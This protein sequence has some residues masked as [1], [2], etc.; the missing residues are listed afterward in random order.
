MLL[1]KSKK[2]L[3]GIAAAAATAVSAQAAPISYS[4]AISGDLSQDFPAEYIG[5]LDIGINTIQGTFCFAR[6][7][8]TCPDTGR[9]FD[10]DGFRYT[11][12]EGLSLDSVTYAFASASVLYAGAHTNFWL[13]QGINLGDP[14]L[15]G[16][17]LDA[18]TSGTRS[19]FASALPISAPGEYT[20]AQPGSGSSGFDGGLLTVNYMWTLSV[21]AV[22]VP[23]PT[24]LGLFG[25][26]LAALLS[27]RRRNREKHPEPRGLKD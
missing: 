26:G 4:E 3:A 18:M 22:E 12:P 1:L 20:I 11:L 15:D 9:G 2:Q 5:T 8:T 16:E 24:T 25:V 23:E 19:M 14:I 21:S 7:P 10:H 6:A 13:M 27:R 17:S